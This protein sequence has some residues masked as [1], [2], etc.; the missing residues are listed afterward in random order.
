MKVR[1]QAVGKLPCEILARDSGDDYAF[2]STQIYRNIELG[3]AQY[4]VAAGESR[5]TNGTDRPDSPHLTSP[6]MLSLHI[7]IYAASSSGLQL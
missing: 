2:S 7:I 3:I 6:H 4:P 1:I 5:G